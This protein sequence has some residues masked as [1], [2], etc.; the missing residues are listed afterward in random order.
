MTHFTDWGTGI[1]QELMEQITHPFFSTKPTGKGT[2]LGLSIS[3]KIIEDHGGS[4]T[5]ESTFGEFTRVTVELPTN[6]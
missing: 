1:K 6:S 2:G 3:R 5:I 4:L